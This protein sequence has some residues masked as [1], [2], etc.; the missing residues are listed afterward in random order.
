[1]PNHMST[2]STSKA[3]LGDKTMGTP[4]PGTAPP[5]WTPESAPPHRPDKAHSSKLPPPI[6][7]GGDG[8]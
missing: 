6:H 5:Q 4:G 3:P 1:M 8:Q 2:P 7:H